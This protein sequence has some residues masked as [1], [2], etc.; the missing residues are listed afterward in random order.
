MEQDK[1]FDVIMDQLNEET[2]SSLTNVRV[3]DHTNAK[4]VYDLLRGPQRGIVSPLRLRLMAYY[5]ADN[6]RNI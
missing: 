4:V 5:E 1:T 3:L 6:D 2:T